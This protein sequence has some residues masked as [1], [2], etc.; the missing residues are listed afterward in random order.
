MGVRP[1]YVSA[2]I[3]KEKWD[4]FRSVDADRGHLHNPKGRRLMC[5]ERLPLP[6]Q[7][8]R[9]TSDRI[10]WLPAVIL[11]MEDF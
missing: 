4:A 6:D 9:H 5:E 2:R 8:G 3:W 11:R 10:V 7:S 1:D